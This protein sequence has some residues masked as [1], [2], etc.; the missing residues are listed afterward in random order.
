M[1]SW[2]IIMKCFKYR[3]FF[4]FLVLIFILLTIQSVQLSK[5]DRKSKSVMSTNFSTKMLSVDCRAVKH[6]C[7]TPGTASTISLKSSPDVT[8][9]KIVY[10]DWPATVEN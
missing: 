1:K 5:C 9:E 4:L 8:I 3:R 6:T 7:T 10:L 2:Q